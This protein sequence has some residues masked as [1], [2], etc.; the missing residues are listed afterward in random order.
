LIAALAELVEARNNF[1][2]F[3]PKFKICGKH[4]KIASIANY[5]SPFIFNYSLI[6]FSKLCQSIAH[7]FNRGGRG[8]NMHKA[9]SI[10]NFSFSIHL[11]LQQYE[12]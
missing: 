8:N 5:F 4:F 7:G 1:L 10:F 11:A 12:I 9:F 6:T 3:L 2:S